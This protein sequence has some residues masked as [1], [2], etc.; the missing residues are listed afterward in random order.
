MRTV[1]FAD[2]LSIFYHTRAKLVTRFADKINR[3]VCR[4]GQKLMAQVSR[5]QKKL[6][7]LP[8]QL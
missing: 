7:Q 2:N 1:A 8:Q 5:G 6:Q 4:H 3:Q